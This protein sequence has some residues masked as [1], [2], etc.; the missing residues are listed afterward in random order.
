[1]SK[2]PAIPDFTEDVQ[3]IAAALRVVKQAI[4]VIGG[5]GVTQ[6]LGAPEVFVQENEPKPSRL[7]VFKL[8]DLWVNPVSQKLYFWDSRQWQSLV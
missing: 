8:G 3:S 6:S 5:Q 7:G 2:I 4:Q 1:M